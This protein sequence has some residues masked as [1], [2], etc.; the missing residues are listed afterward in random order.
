MKSHF[1]CLFRK[2]VRQM[3]LME[4]SR[5]PVSKQAQ[6]NDNENAFGYIKMVSIFL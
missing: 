1:N 2:D 6:Q 3:S 4:V 5:S